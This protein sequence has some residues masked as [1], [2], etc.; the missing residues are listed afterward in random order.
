LWRSKP[1]LN[2]GFTEK[3]QNASS[4]AC[5]LLTSG[6]PDHAEPD[7]HIDDDLVAEVDDFIAGHGTVTKNVSHKMM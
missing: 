1:D 7:D 4:A 6:R 3:I 5:N 2:H